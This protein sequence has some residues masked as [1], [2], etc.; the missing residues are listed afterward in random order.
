MILFISYLNIQNPFLL[1]KS[2]Q[3]R[4]VWIGNLYPCRIYHSILMIYI[5]IKNISKLFVLR[6]LKIFL[7][8][9][10][11]KFNPEYY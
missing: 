5:K 11:Y 3:M 9:Y 8:F 2:F 1:Y 10:T 4:M 6:I 7:L